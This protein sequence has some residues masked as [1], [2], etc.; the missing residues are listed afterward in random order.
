MK[1]GH[2]IAAWLGLDGNALRRPADKAGAYG[3]AV[4]LAVFLIGTPVACTATGVW[5]Y[6]TVMAEQRAQQS[7]H[8][9][10]A[11]VLNPVSPQGAYY[12]GIAW[13]WASWTVAG[14][15]H[16][17]AIPVN[18]GTRAGARIRAWVD[19]SGQW[20]GPPLS[21]GGAL[22]Q[23]ADY[24]VLTPVALGTVLLALAAAGHYLLDRRRMARWASD[25]A[26]VGPQWTRQFW[27]K[28]R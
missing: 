22:L 23:V 6:H 25:W 11:V 28:G 20:S 19:A 9:V 3:R 10:Q 7:W 18:T 1:R 16:E 4:L 17:G 14:H 15:R 27:A 26:R 5:A 13:T 12:G 8:Q 24:V 2:R 21:R